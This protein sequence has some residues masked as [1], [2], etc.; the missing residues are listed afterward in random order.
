MD[1]TSGEKGF[2]DTNYIFLS[3]VTHYLPPGIV[4]L[5]I[6]VIFAI[7]AGLRDAREGRPPYFWSLLTNRA[8]RIEMIK[9]DHGLA[10]FETRGFLG[11]V[12][13]ELNILH[14]AGAGFR[15]E[16]EPR[17]GHQRLQPRQSVDQ[18]DT[19]FL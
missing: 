5:V 6:A 10:D 2:K 15:A 11:D 18:L 1:Q 19:L 13:T 9:D 4:G 8:H 3:F 7:R 12:K 14:L 17:P 16:L